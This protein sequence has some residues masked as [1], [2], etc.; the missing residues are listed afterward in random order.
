MSSFSWTSAVYGD[1]STSNLWSDD[2]V[3][4]SQVPPG[5]SDDVTIDALGAPYVVTISSDVSASSLTVA[6]VDAA[7][8]L[9]G[10]TIAANSYDNGAGSTLS[11]FGTVAALFTN[12]GSVDAEGGTLA[13]TAAGD[14]FDGTLSGE[15]KVELLANAD[16]ESASVSVANLSI[17][18]AGV[19]VTADDDFT[20]SSNFQIGAGGAL[21]VGGAIVVTGVN[22]FDGDVNGSGTLNVAG[23]ATTFNAG[24][25][26]ELDDLAQSGGTM[27]FD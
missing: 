7:V 5:T 27:A 11:G 24:A 3:A 4:G 19:S 22:A 6:G 18:G 2:G 10:E 8:S 13:F 23:G 25:T 17:Q 12:E 9:Q 1:W 20:V 21:A 16:L 14:L 26:I 15:G